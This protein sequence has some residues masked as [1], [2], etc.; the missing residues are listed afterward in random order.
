[1][2]RHLSGP[3]L[4][5]QHSAPYRA[6]VSRLR[7]CKIPAMAEKPDWERYSAY[8]SEIGRKGGKARA[9][10]LTSEQRREIATKASN[11]A[12]KA[13]TAKARKAAQAKRER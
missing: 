10:R 11:A 7:A 8:F 4:R 6:K 1:M 9:E 3:F 13:R 12:A 5:R 2:F